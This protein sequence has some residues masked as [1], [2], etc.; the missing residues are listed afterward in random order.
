MP[1]YEVRGQM[2]EPFRMSPV[3]GRA[4]GRTVRRWPCRSP[5]SSPPAP[6]SPPPRPRSRKRPLRH[7]RRRP[8]RR[9][10][11]PPLK[12]RQ[13]H[14]SFSFMYLGISGITFCTTIRTMEGEQ[15]VRNCLKRVSQSLNTR[16]DRNNLLRHSMGITLPSCLRKTAMHS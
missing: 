10:P 6:R 11:I 9:R 15:N 2:D 8:R 3:R 13:S 1:R 16:L 5:P 4:E 7:R 14:L 12:I